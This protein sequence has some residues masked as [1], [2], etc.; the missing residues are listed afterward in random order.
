MLTVHHQ[1]ELDRQIA[2]I[3]IRI[4][5]M[6]RFNVIAPARS[7]AWA[8]VS[9]VKWSHASAP[10]QCNNALSRAIGVKARWKPKS[11]TLS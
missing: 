3:H 8:D 2:E 6:N 5:L 4:V 1:A 11:T 9:G 10:R 7:S